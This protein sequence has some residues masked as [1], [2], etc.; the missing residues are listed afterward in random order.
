VLAAVANRMLRMLKKNDLPLASF[1][2]FRTTLLAAALYLLAFASNGFGFHLITLST[3]DISWSRIPLSMGVLALSG[4]I[5]MIV[6]FAPAG[7][8]AREG[9]IAGTLAPVIGVQH[10]AVVALLSRVWLTAVDLILA[11]GALLVDYTSGD[12]LLSGVIA[13]RRRHDTDSESQ[14]PR[15]EKARAHPIMPTEAGSLE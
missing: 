5:G 12:R 3:V 4:A 10:A 6:L 15:L 2:D 11:G 7:L 14:T 1:P 8:G 13:G 9:S